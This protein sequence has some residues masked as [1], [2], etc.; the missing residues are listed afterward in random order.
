ML[1]K[2]K[3]LIATLLLSVSF[4]YGQTGVGTIKGSVKDKKTSEELPFVK[5]VVYQNGVQK[6]YAS[7]DFTGGF[8]ISSL[9]P[10]EYD[11]EI[12]YIGYNSIKEEG[13]VVNSDKLIVRNYELTASSE[14]LD[15]VEVISYE[16]PLID[17]D[18]GAS[19][20]TVT[21]DDISKMSARSATGVAS[22]VGGVYSAEG[23]GEGLSIRGARSDATYYYIDGIKVRGSSALPKSA[24]Q[25]VSVITGGV[26]ANYGDLTGGIISITTRG[27]SSRYFGSFEL[28]S[29]GFYFNG[30]DPAGYDGKVVGLDNYAFNLAEGM[31]SGPLLMK[32]DSSGTKTKPILGF[33][34]S[35]NF[36]DVLDSRPLANGGAYRIKK[37]VRDDLLNDSTGI[38]PLRP[39]GEGQGSYYNTSFLTKDDFEQVKYRMNTRNRSM[40]AA[41]KIDVNAGPNVNLTFG[42]SMNWSKG[43]GYSYQNSLMNF[44]NFGSN[45]RYDWRVY[46]KFTQRFQ[47]SEEGS[48]SKVKSAYYSLMVDYSQSHSKSE[49]GRHKDKLFN[50]G[51]VGKFQTF[52]EITY[53]SSTGGD[54]LIHNGFNDTLVVFT[55]SEVNQ[56]FAAQTSQYYN[57]YEGQVEG[58]YENLNQISAGFGLRNG[59]SPQN[60]YGIWNNLGTPY[61]FYGVS[62]NDQLRIKYMQTQIQK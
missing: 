24:I 59:D 58:N 22:T 32:K 35:A 20:A 55:P 15:V 53:E 45:T 16:V 17:L 39:T 25:E 40:S 8:I 28:V 52:R 50:Y 43:N 19:G 60:V 37:D 9:S 33:F 10:G 18:G 27:P 21:R 1:H 3:L 13:V 57:L 2:L 47:N 46:G 31:I 48:T 30:E 12:K 11:V 34:L 61:N 44:D 36:T 38:G 23:G 62:Q 56:P 41:G 6:G 51:Y 49:D 29:S 5:V 26:P 14:M 54:S 42:G 4:T 7:T